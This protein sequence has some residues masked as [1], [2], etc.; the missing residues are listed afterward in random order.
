MAKRKTTRKTSAK[1][2]RA[3]A[4]GAK[5]AKRSTAARGLDLKKVRADM[6]LAIEAMKRSPVA[7]VGERSAMDSGQAQLEEM[8]ARINDYCERDRRCGTGMIIPI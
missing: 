3:K 5:R 8:V 2:P 7:A 6:L 4:S 1:R